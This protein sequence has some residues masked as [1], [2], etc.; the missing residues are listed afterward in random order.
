MSPTYTYADAQADLA[1]VRHCE[2]QLDNLDEFTYSDY[3]EA[4]Y[5][6]R[7]NGWLS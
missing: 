4:L 3:L 7:T 1:F 5:D 6:L 2:E